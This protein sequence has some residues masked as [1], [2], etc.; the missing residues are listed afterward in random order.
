[1]PKRL[2]LF[3]I[4]LKSISGLLIVGV[5]A[6]TVYGVITFAKTAYNIGYS[7]FNQTAYEQN[8]RNISITIPEGAGSREVV[9][10]LYD[11]GLVENKFVAYLQL[12]LSKYDKKIVPGDYVLNSSMLPDEL[13]AEMSKQVNSDNTTNVEK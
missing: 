13:F 9:Q 4:I 12:K 2:K 11:N 8:G 3:E 5:I 10:R 1:M 6:V 7:T